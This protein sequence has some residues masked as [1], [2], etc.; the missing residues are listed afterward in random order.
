MDIVKF[1]NLKSLKSLMK[2]I[3]ENGSIN[4]TSVIRFDTLSQIDKFIETRNED[5]TKHVKF[6]HT[7]QPVHMINLLSYL[8]FNKILELDKF[9]EITDDNVERKLI[10][11]PR[12]NPEKVI[13][14]I[15]R[16]KQI[17]RADDVG[18][19]VDDAN[20]EVADESPEVVIEGEN[21]D[22]AEIESTYELYT[23]AKANSE[24]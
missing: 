12:V 10:N 11:E 2:T 3:N 17:I 16:K 21:G 15:F 1:N 14:L 9:T 5:E 8:S 7:T 22:L 4:I 20:E 13:L 6:Y 24:A 19:T 18:N 23:K